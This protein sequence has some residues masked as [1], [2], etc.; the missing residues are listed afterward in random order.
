MTIIADSPPRVEES[1]ITVIDVYAAYAR[2][3]YEPAE[4]ASAFGIPL[5]DVH[6]ALAYYY[7]HAEEMRG[8]EDNDDLQTVE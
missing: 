7:R 8:Y 6:E 4:V 5:A 2:D 3:G 1:G